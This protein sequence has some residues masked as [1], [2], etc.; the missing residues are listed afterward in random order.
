MF[1]TAALAVGAK[2]VPDAFNKFR[3]FEREQDPYESALFPDD[4]SWVDDPAVELE[5]RGF[6]GDSIM[7]LIHGT[8]GIGPCF[9]YRYYIDV[10]QAI[11]MLTQVAFSSDATVFEIYNEDEWGEDLDLTFERWQI[12]LILASAL[13]R[14]QTMSVANK[15]KR[16]EFIL[17][18]CDSLT[19][20]IE[21]LREHTRDM[22]EKNFDEF[23]KET[24]DRIFKFD[25]TNPRHW[26]W[27]LSKLKPS[28]S[29]I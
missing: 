18:I 16:L 27:A 10:N 2:S 17:S 23:Y 29:G 7:A 11:S 22:S 5:R 12:H 21:T 28:D 26:K 9:G 24:G 8:E 6:N 13:L 1:T 4:G 14:I 15:V 19:F 20:R 3:E 25:E